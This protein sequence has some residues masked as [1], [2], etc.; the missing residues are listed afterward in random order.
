M[1]VNPISNN[2][3]FQAKFVPNSILREAYQ[4][5]KITDAGK[6][7]LGKFNQIGKDQEV[8]FVNRH[9][10]NYL[11]IDKF[12]LFNRTTGKTACVTVDMNEPLW[13]KIL[14]ALVED[15]EFFKPN[16]L[17]QELTGQKVVSW[18]K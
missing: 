6:E 17:W 15:K 4:Y 10:G 3:S 11:N 2:T 8:E 1:Q 9:K 18:M 7:L 16:R 12:E 13:D 14:K 5:G